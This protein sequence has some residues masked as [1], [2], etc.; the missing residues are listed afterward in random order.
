MATKI[1]ILVSALGFA[2]LAATP[3]MAKSHA[4]HRQTTTTTFPS[5]VVPPHA[6]FGPDGTLLGSDPDPAVR[7]QMMR[8]WGT[9]L[10]T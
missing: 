7:L 5:A 6:A 2:A 4:Q 3:V 1:K 8:D 9:N 10:K